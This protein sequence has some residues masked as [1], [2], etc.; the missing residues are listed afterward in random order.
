MKGRNSRTVKVQASL[1]ETRPSCTI[2][3]VS[4]L[5]SII[6]LFKRSRFTESCQFKFFVIVATV[7]LL[8]R[9]IH[10]R[11]RKINL[12]SQTDQRVHV[13]R[14]ANWPVPFPPLLR[15]RKR[16]TR[17]IS[18]PPNDVVPVSAAFSPRPLKLLDFISRTTRTSLDR[19]R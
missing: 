6:Y 12:T 7:T 1:F 11:K 18:L 2:I 9:R 14:E 15:Q 8:A 13:T 16:E 19:H 3:Y 5:F 10:V 17:V 4:F